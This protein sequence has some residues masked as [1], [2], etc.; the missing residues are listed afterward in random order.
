MEGMEQMNWQELTALLFTLIMTYVGYKV[1][2]WTI[3]LKSKRFKLTDHQLFIQLLN[4]ISEV[5]S[6]RVPLNRLVLKDALII[7]LECWYNKGIEFA[8]QVENK[9]FN[10]MGIERAV[11]EWANKTI[12]EYNKQWKSAEINRI[13]ISK[14]NHRHQKKVDL[15]INAFTRIAHNNIYINEKLKFI[16]IFD[17]LNVLLAETKNDFLDMIFM[18]NFN[19]ELRGQKYKGIPLNDIEFQ[20][21]QNNKNKANDN[22]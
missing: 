1:K 6:W 18:R 4:T 12:I 21:Y 3:R 8:E 2:D 16:A 14:I 22:N 17:A 10:D 9:R 13:I 11:A 20:E 19:G 7:K 15:F 5:N